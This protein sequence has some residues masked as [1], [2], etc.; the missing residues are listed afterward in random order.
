MPAPAIS[1]IICTYNP[2]AD[3]LAR[4][5]EGLKAQ[6]LGLA[7]WEFLLI[8]NHSKEPLEGR[9]DLSWHPQGRVVREDKLGLT[10]ARLCGFREAR[11]ELLVYVDDDNI[12]ATDYLATAQRIA[13]EFPFLGT[14]GGAIVP[15]F[16][17]KPA[18][19][20]ELFL[21][22]LALRR[23]DQRRWSNFDGSCEPFGAGMCVRRS[24]M[25][26]FVEWSKNEPRLIAL[27][28]TGTGLGSCEDNAI[29]RSGRTHGL[30][31]GVFPELTLTHLI[32][33]NRLQRE[34]LERL[35]ENI[36]AYSRLLLAIEH[37]PYCEPKQSRGRQLFS[38]FTH[39]MELRLSSKP[40]RALRRAE[41]R[42]D[43]KG[44]EL[45][46]KIFGKPKE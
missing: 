11:G 39:E 43:K 2:R 18:P 40:Y 6:T 33:T 12:L 22:A 8:D 9:V 38:R 5:L 46:E 32:P 29:A 21:P 1:V 27:G 36:R 10:N 20:L 28:R 41:Q 37:G 25:A 42:G 23:V 14:F 3:Y 15:E 30:G 34:Y 26:A 13:R 31:W 16:E 24:C 44:R 4:T 19:E 45:V 35:V 17:T 7:E